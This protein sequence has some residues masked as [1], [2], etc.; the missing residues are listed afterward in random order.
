MK[1]QECRFR[2][3]FS[4]F[5]RFSLLIGLCVAVGS[6]PVLLIAIIV[7]NKLTHGSYFFPG[8][9][10]MILLI[11]IVGFPVISVLSFAMYA[12]LAFPMYSHLKA[13]TYTEEFEL[14]IR[15][16]QAHL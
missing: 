3:N 11:I 13:R 6:I 5:F 10:S 1:Q 14:V 4:S 15:E 12:I 7:I 2:L 16:N 9:F 8:D